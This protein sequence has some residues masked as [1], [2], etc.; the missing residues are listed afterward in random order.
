MHTI[1]GWSAQGLALGLSALLC[2]GTG[3]MAGDIAAAAAL[4]ETWNLHG[5][6][7]NVAQWHPAFTA[8]YSGQNS[9]TPREIVKETSDLTLFFGV[10]L[11]RG[12]EFYLNPEFDQGFG[13][14]N[15]LGVAGFPSGEA[16]KVGAD[17]P[18]YRLPRAFLRQ[19]IGLGSEEQKIEAG[20]NR[21]A[22]SAPTNNVTLTIGK[23]SAV[24]IFD[25]NAY[26]H[27]PRSDFLNW[28]AVDAG[29]YDYAADAWGY[30]YGVAAEWNL[31]WWTLRA[32]LF[33]LSDVPNSS[34]LDPHFGQFEW[35]GEFE[36][37]KN[38]RGHPGKLKF[39]AYENRGLMGAYGDAVRL[40]QQTGTTPDTVRVRHFAAR[41]GMALNLEQELESDL[42]F[43]ARASLNDGSKEAFEFTEIDRSVSLG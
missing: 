39:L 5:Q 41:P 17:A 29:A 38:W 36:A 31:S 11:W 40:G 19:V 42:G 1:C 30:T 18:Y 37:R 25:N 20:A 4:Q 8:P 22:G 24:D 12:G 35:V 26:A 28:S 33:D 7:T 43:F 16:Y 34:R 14:N 15:T 21:L 23:F 13:F 2:A 9:L 6:F 27:D 3:A 10:R 32:G